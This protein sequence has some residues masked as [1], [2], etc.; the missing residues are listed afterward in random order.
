MR[1][2]EYI[3]ANQ[4]QVMLLLPAD[5]EKCIDSEKAGPYVSVALLKTGPSGPVGYNILKSILKH[6]T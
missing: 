5:C 3:G 4:Q 2:S 6:G 1:F